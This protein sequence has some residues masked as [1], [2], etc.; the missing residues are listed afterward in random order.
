MLVH[1]KSLEHLLVSVEAQRHYGQTHRLVR[2]ERRSCCDT[3]G[4]AAAFAAHVGVGRLLS[5]GPACLRPTRNVTPLV[6][7]AHVAF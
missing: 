3:L 7:R 5:I 6:L 4:V 2:L 1:H